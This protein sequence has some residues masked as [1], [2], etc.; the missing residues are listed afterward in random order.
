MDTAKKLIHGC[1]NGDE[2]A[3]EQLVREYQL[4]LYRL[5][6]S[7]L[8]DHLEADEATQDA[9]LAA[10]KG[11]SSYRGEAALS[12]WLY[13]ITLNVCRSRLRRRKG[14]ERLKKAIRAI[15]QLGEGRGESLGDS[16]AHPEDAM[17]QDEAGV[18]LWNA[19]EA[20]GEKHRLPVLLYYY[21]DLPVSEIALILGIPEGT[22]YSRLRTAHDRLRDRLGSSQADEDLPQREPSKPAGVVTSQPACGRLQGGGS[23]D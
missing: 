11:L 7:V 3:I 16:P 17:I 8:D 2:D 19:V 4:P 12:T 22:V 5:A 6:L 23:Y 13:S 15:F 10:L 1:Q 20:L 18:A 14:W 9:F 21:H